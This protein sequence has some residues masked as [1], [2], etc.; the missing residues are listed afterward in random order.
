MT[1]KVSTL[2]RVNGE[3]TKNGKKLTA[4]SIEFVVK[5]A[6]RMSGESIA[7]VLHRPVSTVRTIARRMGVSLKL[8]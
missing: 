1:K 6:G 2:S 5:N 8:Q 4:G 3:A 7:K